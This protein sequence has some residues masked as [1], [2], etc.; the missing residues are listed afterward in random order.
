[1]NTDHTPIATIGALLATV[2]LGIIGDAL[3]LTIAPRPLTASNYV[4]WALIFSSLIHKLGPWA[5][6][7]YRH[8]TG[9]ASWAKIHAWATRYPGLQGWVTVAGW[10]WAIAAVLTL[11]ITILLVWRTPHKPDQ[12]LRGT[13]LTENIKAYRQL[14]RDLEREE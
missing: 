7:H 8:V 10:W 14:Q 3:I 12:F 11:V 2:I 1:M 4:W 6:S 9:L 5:F 13:H